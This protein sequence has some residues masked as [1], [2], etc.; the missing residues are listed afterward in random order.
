MQSKARETDEK[1]IRR[2]KTRDTP[3]PPGQTL[4]ENFEQ[5]Y[6]YANLN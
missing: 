4:S 2:E 3:P 1:Y 6:S 5:K